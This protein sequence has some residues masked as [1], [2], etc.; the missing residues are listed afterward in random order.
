MQQKLLLSLLLVLFGWGASSAHNPVWTLDIA[1]ILYKH[2]T[3]C[4]HDGGLAP[5]PLV[6]Y[7]DAYFNRFSIEF[8][9]KNV[10][11]TMLAILRRPSF[12]VANDRYQE[13]QIGIINQSVTNIA[14]G[15]WLCSS[16]AMPGNSGGG[17]FNNKGGR[18][19]PGENGHSHHRK[20]PF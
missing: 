1:P 18:C 9:L 6:T 14:E 12:V 3:P 15:G 2:C 11:V 4:H 10:I 20:N 19:Q 13:K 8:N 17:V 16:P 7:E 5:F